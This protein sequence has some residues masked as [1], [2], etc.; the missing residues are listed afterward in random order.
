MADA[1]RFLRA[2]GDADLSCYL[3][4]GAGRLSALTVGSTVVPFLVPSKRRGSSYVCSP[5]AHY[6]G[7]PRDELAKLHGPLER[8][9][10]R[11]GLSAAGALC[12]ATRFDDVVYVNNWLL[13]TNPAPRL[14]GDDVL[15]ITRTLTRSFPRQAIVFRSVNR[16]LDPEYAAALED[17]GYV[18]VPS[19]QVY[20]LDCQSAAVRQNENIRRDRNLLDKSGYAVLTAASMT[21]DDIARLAFLYRGL[22]LEK[23][24]RLNQAFTERFFTILIDARILEFAA[25]RRDGR[26]DAFTA[27]YHRPGLVTG[28]LLGYDTSLPASAGLY[29][30]AVALLIRAATERAAMLNLSGGARSFKVFRGAVA[31]VEYD[32]VY[33]RHLPR[34][35]EPAWRL[36]KRAGRFH[37]RSARR[38]AAAPQGRVAITTTK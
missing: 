34:W 7:Y 38:K 16:R 8:V 33:L 3:S 28:A 21:H 14:S 6:I 31:C 29:R 11:L 17:Q 5:Y 26:I 32:A 37:D 2:C 19:R 12:R 22:Y 24:S 15:T 10:R 18:M 30:Q 20:L 9:V 35:R 25:L 23:H 27:F 13:S 4:N 36:M 1:A